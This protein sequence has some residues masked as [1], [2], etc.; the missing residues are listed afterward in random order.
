MKIRN[1]KSDIR[2]VEHECLT[3]LSA[4]TMIEI[5]ISLAVIA[6][7][8]VAIIGVLPT[9]MSVQRENRE[10]TIINQDATLW[11]GA[12]RNGERG[13]DDLTNY[14][15]AIT[16]YVRTYTLRGPAPP[17][18][19]YWYTYTNSSL[20]PEFALTNG[21]RIIGLLSTPKYTWE[22]PS[23]KG[24]P[25]NMVSNHVVAVV[26]SMSGPAGEKAPQTNASV[27]ELALS[28]KLIA[29]VVPF[30]G[31]NTIDPVSTNFNDPAILN[32]TNFPEL[33]RRKDM[34]ALARNIEA[35]TYQLR[36]TFRWPVLA[37]GA[38]G[39]GRQVF[40]SQVSGELLP[41]IEPDYLSVATNDPP[42]LDLTLYFFQ[43]RTFVRIPRP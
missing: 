34:Y 32:P 39:N 21:A 31:T 11:L 3:R 43:P 22:P 19:P 38:A 23:A 7:A 13:L 8:L 12:I 26:R 9:G 35:N 5:A 37:S 29:D 36:L 1:P 16:N 41:Y 28:Y 42:R 14:V 25:G 20:T 15:I 17:Q 30:F 40:R 2:R 6:F 10:E 33:E 24:L 4:F 18:A 27:Q